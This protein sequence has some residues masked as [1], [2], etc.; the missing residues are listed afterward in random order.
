MGGLGAAAVAD[1]EADAARV[2]SGAWPGAG[3][4][5]SP[6]LR[7]SLQHFLCDGQLDFWHSLPQKYAMPH[8]AH[9]SRCACS[10]L[11]PLPAPPP[12]NSVLRETPQPAH[13]LLALDAMSANASLV[14]DPQCHTDCI[15]KYL[16]GARSRTSKARDA[17]WLKNPS[18]PGPHSHVDGVVLRKQVRI[19]IK[20]RRLVGELVDFR[21][22]RRASTSKIC[23]STRKHSN[24]CD[25]SIF[26]CNRARGLALAIGC[27]ESSGGGGRRERSYGSAGENRHNL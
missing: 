13:V 14:P 26:H 4:K 15:E 17:R 9:A 22:V 18:S 19:R 7:S 1:P 23:T 2:V 16:T 12:E 8:P 25:A 11:A 6:P 20:V 3:P 27:V 5:R 21:V 24:R 10:T